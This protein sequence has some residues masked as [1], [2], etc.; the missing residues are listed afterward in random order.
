MYGLEMGSNPPG[1]TRTE[2]PLLKLPDEILALILLHVAEANQGF[3]DM[4]L[5]ERNR[6]FPARLAGCSIVD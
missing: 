5:R 1:G 6:M 3:L 2:S 4:I